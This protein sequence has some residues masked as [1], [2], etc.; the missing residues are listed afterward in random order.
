MTVPAGP[1]RRTVVRGAAWATPAVAV[2][3]TAPAFAA[4][5]C[6]TSNCPTISFGTVSGTGSDGI[7]VATA[8]NGWTASPFPGTWTN[9]SAS[10]PVGF[11][12]PT[13]GG[14]MTTSMGPW[15]AATAEPTTAG[16]VINLNQTGQPGLARGCSYTIRFGVVTWNASAVPLTLRV[17]V[18][19][20]QV[21]QYVTGTNG[22][23]GYVDRGYQT[24]TVPSTASGVVSFQFA[25]TSGDHGDIKLYDPS[26]ICA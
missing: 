4:S 9:R 25:F 1:R 17:L 18:G 2:A 23:S 5:P 14:G 11:R 22:A 20:T 16:Q 7:G 21:G 8:G 24:V 19:G 10:N 6:T 12:A 3:V 13:T 26:V 15:F